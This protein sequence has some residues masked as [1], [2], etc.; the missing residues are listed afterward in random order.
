MQD[1][2][3]LLHFISLNLAGLRKC[4]KKLAK[5]HGLR[6]P[7]TNNAFMLEASHP[8]EGATWVQVPP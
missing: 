4:L 7:T 2:S 6:G 3:H 1:V 8:S 5:H